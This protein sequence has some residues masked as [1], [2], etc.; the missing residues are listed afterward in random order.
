MVAEGGRVLTSARRYRF[1]EKPAL[2]RAI[3]NLTHLSRDPTRHP[4]DNCFSVTNTL[5]GQGYAR[6][7]FF[8]SSLR[9]TC[10]LRKRER[11]LDSMQPAGSLAATA[12]AAA[13]RSCSLPRV[14]G[15]RARATTLLQERI[16]P[17]SALPQR[18]PAPGTLYVASWMCTLYEFF[19]PHPHPLFFIVRAGFNWDTSL[20]DAAWNI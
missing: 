16:A 1:Y 14:S 4:C 5:W 20:L 9:A 12:A 19:T 18:G 8:F 13:A 7:F 15:A 2:D 17:P 3:C 10:T 6:A 11:H